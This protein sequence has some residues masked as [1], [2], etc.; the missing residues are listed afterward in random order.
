MLPLAFFVSV[1]SAGETDQ[2][3]DGKFSMPQSGF[4][5]TAPGWHMARWSDW[6]WKGRTADSAVFG[7]AWSTSYQLVLDDEVAKGL[8]A[9]W[10][11]LIE[12]EEGGADVAVTSVKVEE[13]AGQKRVRATLTFTARGG[14]KGVCHAAAFATRGLT[15]QVWTIAPS[16]GSE[17]AAK[18]LDQLLTQLELTSPPAALGAT[19][20]LSDDA[21]ELVLPSGWRLPLD[22]EATEVTALY[23]KTGAKDSRL[24]TAAIHPYVGGVADVLLL[25]SEA[26]NAVVVDE[27]SFAD[28]AVLFGQQLFGKA[29]EKLP[30]AEM[31][32]RGQGDVAILVHANTGLWAGGVDTSTGTE[33]IWTSGAD[34]HD[35]ALG[36][37]ARAALKSLKLNDDAQPN[38]GL[39]ALVFHRMTY[40][41]TH[42]MV[43]VPGLLAL[44]LLGGIIMMILRSTPKPGG[45]DPHGY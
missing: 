27:F 41:P 8:T 4:T 18:Q 5:L 2:P 29:A 7:R 26:G 13:V 38:P 17:R 24:C 31:V 3:V 11:A 6:D 22:A 32:V 35:T 33:V 34:G 28:E 15:A 45:D 44:G 1:A 36:D 12:S 10:K 20:T 39:G 14:L 21:G 9:E 40:Q 43:L 30:P 25:C 23:G 19:E 16:Q 37:T 42:P